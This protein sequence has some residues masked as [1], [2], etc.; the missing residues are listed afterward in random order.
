MPPQAYQQ[1]FNPMVY[2]QV[3]LDH[4]PLVDRD[5]K[6]HETKS[7]FDLFDVYCWLKDKILD[8]ADDIIIWETKIP[9]YIFPKT[10]S[11]PELIRKC[12]SDYDINQRDIMN[13]IGEI[14]F[15]LNAPSIQEMMQAPIVENTIPFSYEALIGLY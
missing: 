1:P 14:F 12:Q 3:D 11:F 8:E 13:V 15:Y 4:I 7:D 10:H 9:H 5:Y 2:P 6:I